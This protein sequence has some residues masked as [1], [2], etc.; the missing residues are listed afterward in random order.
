MTSPTT[1]AEDVEVLHRGLAEQVPDQVLSPL[2]AE[3]EMLDAA[4]VPKAAA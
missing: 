4:G 3:Q 1:I 2:F